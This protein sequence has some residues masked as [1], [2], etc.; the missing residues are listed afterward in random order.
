MI[1]STIT[2]SAH[3]NS[4]ELVDVVSDSKELIDTESNPK[5]DYLEST[6]TSDGNFDTD[7][8]NRNSP[9]KLLANIKYQRSS[10]VSSLRFT[11]WPLM[12]FRHVEG[13]CMRYAHFSWRI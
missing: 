11:K 3:S 9:H 1:Q 6:H 4:E 2:D 12:W 7:T 13:L 10:K 8:T 5:S